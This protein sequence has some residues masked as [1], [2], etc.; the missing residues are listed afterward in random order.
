MDVDGRR[1]RL[2][3]LDK[4]LYP[5]TGFTKGAVI[6]YYTM[7]APVLLPHLAGRPLSLRRR[8]D[9][10]SGQSFWDKDADTL[11]GERYRLPARPRAADHRR[12]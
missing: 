2:S 7:V 11:L 3:N 6:D 8:P 4:V 12:R 9:G 1:R 10:V 5:E